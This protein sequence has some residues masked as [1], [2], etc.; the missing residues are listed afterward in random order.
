MHRWHM[1]WGMAAAAVAGIAP[2]AMAQPKAQERE[3]ARPRLVSEF[4]SI[5][6]GK[7]AWLGVSFDID[8]EWH[9][10]WPGQNDSGFPT[11]LN[12]SAPDGYK[13]GEQQFPAPVRHISDGELLD[14]VYEGRVTILIPVE[15]PADAK[16]GS[17][18]SF[19]VEGNWLVCKTVCVAGSA[20]LDLSVP[21]A[22]A[23][24][25]PKPSAAAP[26]FAKAR[27]RL[28]KPLPAGDPHVSLTWKGDEITIEA[29]KAKQLDFYPGL[30]SGKVDDLVKSGEIKG[31]T[32][33]LRVD[34][35]SR[36][37]GVLEIHGQ[38]GEDPTVYWIDSRPGGAN[39]ATPGPSNHVGSGGG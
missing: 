13:V 7:T 11:T 25:T 8:P 32:L 9:I 23:G 6:P 24:S 14:H 36:V 31:D 27:A 12:V 5:V 15:V 38:S 2:F 20:T 1:G 4:D 26:L 18:A 16:P 34:G 22:E 29:T 35:A 10:Y 39:P 28:P 30:E 19:G 33:R 17:K 3:H 21:I 37:A